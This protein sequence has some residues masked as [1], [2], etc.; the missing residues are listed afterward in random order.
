MKIA[1]AGTGYVGLSNTMLLAHQ[2]EVVAPA[3]TDAK[4]HAIR[5]LQR[6]QITIRVE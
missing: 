1:I 3:P 6:Y 5:W 4:K 2:N